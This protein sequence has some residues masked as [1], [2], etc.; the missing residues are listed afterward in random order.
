M[1]KECVVKNDYAHGKSLD[2]F[3]HGTHIAHQRTHARFSC[4]NDDMCFFFAGAICSLPSAPGCISFHPG[5]L[6]KTFQQLFYVNHG[7]AFYFLVS[8]VTTFFVLSSRENTI[9]VSPSVKNIF[10]H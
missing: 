9:S 8:H 2:N 1:I 4:V 10:V 5:A 6:E 3:R 7:F